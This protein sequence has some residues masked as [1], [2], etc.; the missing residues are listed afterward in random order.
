MGPDR[1]GGA[2]GN[3][4]A[5]RAGLQM[6]R[7]LLRRVVMSQGDGIVLLPGGEGFLRPDHLVLK[8]SYYVIPA[9]RAL[10]RVLPS[11]HWRALEESG[12]ALASCGRFGRWR[13]P[14]DWV[15][16]PRGA[17]RPGWRRAGPRASPTTRFGCPSTLRGGAHRRRRAALLPRV[18]GAPPYNAASLIMMSQL[19]WRDLSVPEPGNPGSSPSAAGAGSQPW[20]LSLLSPGR[21]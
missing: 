5:P 7:D 15:T 16:L 19:A 12:V 6:G 9:F 14:P 17:G 1:G 20:L 18:A 2:L 21:R 8:P 13:L 3:G 4:A 10:D 11:R